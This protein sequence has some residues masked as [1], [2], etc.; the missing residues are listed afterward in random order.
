MDQGPP[1]LP[2]DPKARAHSRVWSDHIN[3]KIIPLFYKFLQEQDSSKQPAHAAEFK[4][5]IDTLVDA[6]DPN[7]PFFLGDKLSFVD[8]QFAPWIVRL[9][10][11]LVPYR[12]WPEEDEESRWGRWVKAVEEDE[13]VKSTTSGDELY[14]DSYERYARESTLSS[15]FLVCEADLATENRPNTSELAKAI[16]EGKGLP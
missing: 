13:F 11:V 2:S 15:Y 10:K 7:G 9:K 12:G 5:Q 16:N 3:R 14:L 8:V 1:L 4:Q 6:A